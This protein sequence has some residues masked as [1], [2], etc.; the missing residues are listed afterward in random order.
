MLNPSPMKKTFCLTLLAALLTGGC[1]IHRIDIQQ[2][3]IITPEMV[4]TLKVGMTKEQV[5]FVVGTPLIIDAFN[6]DRWIYFYSMQARKKPLERRSV[7]VE[8]RD[9]RVSSFSTSGFATQEDHPS[10]GDQL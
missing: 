2:G 10:P 3:N 4:Q 1:S 7:I 5:Q 6:P 9:G 8:F